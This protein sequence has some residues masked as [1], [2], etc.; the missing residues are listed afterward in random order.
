MFKKTEVT[1]I[2][3]L[4]FYEID[5]YHD[6]RGYFEEVFSAARYG[7][8][9]PKIS[10]VNV[11]CSKKN[12]LRGLHVAPF[13]KLCTC[14]KG[15]LYDVVADVRRESPTYGKWWGTWLCEDVPTQVYV[16]PGCAHGFLS[17]KNGSILLY[18]QSEIYDPSVETQVRYDDPF[19]SIVWPCSTQD[20]I[21]SKKD[22]EAPC[23]S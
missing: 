23:L 6:H 20:C 16:P 14:I 9:P 2:D 15:K 11:S 12:V 10:Q 4:A 3:G 22:L 17:A 21:L 1:I 8:S 5:R 7:D 13:S 18:G 19:L